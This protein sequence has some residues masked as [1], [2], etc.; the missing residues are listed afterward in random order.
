LFSLF[1]FDLFKR[2]WFIF[3]WSNLIIYKN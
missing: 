2:Q 1:G 3:S